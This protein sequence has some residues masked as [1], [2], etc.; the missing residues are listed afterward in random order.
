MAKENYRVCLECGKEFFYWIA[1]Q[2]FCGSD[3]SN[4]FYKK[5]YKEQQRVTR[6][7]IFERD[8]F[9]CAYC[10]RTSYED[11]IK[12]VLDH[13]YPKIRKGDNELDNLITSCSEC[14]GMK[15]ARIM[16]KENLINLWTLVKS[17]NEKNFTPED[18]KFM[19]EQFDKHWRKKSDK[20]D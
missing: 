5:K 18:Y 1:N 20:T 12:L 8:E 9:R 16:S 6:F 19:R 15:G 7:R 17:R 11:N 14:N 3:C 2:K 13:I 10:G 4:V